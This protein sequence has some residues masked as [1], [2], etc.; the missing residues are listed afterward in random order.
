LFALYKVE[1]SLYRVHKYL[2]EQHSD[3]FRGVLSDD[4]DAMGHA[5]DWP[6]P[7][8]ENVTRQAFDTLLGFMYTGIYDPASVSLADWVSLL[9]ISTLLHF[10]KIR[11]HA[12]RELSARRTALAPVDAILLAR[13]HDLPAWLGPAY[14]E[15]VRP[16]RAARRRR[17][18]ALGGAC[19]RAGGAGARGAA[20][21]GVRAVP[22]AQVRLEVYAVGEAG[23]AAGRACGERGVSTATRG[24]AVNTNTC[25]NARNL[26]EG[27]C[28]DFLLSLTCGKTACVCVL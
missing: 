11:E 25:A 16:P 20:R 8:P 2:L 27:L 3:F 6:L 12:I 1:G 14:A 5:D 24:S 4:A 15:L 13:E 7:L 21:G 23:R 26:A 22:A 10:A 18:G 17:G 19:H 9:R 28:F